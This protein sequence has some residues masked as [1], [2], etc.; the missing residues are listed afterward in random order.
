MAANPMLRLLYLLLAISFAVLAL[1][2]RADFPLPE[3]VAR[4]AGDYLWG[5]MLYFLLCALLSTYVGVK[6]LLLALT[7]SY[8]VES[9]QLYQDD[10][11]MKVRANTWGGLLLGHGFLWSDI[12]LYTLGNITGFA[13]SVSF[14]LRHVNARR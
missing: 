10:W 1:L 4:Y 11:I 13:I 6:N 3:L 9:L 2:T 12:L 5:I 14:G 8:S 7:I